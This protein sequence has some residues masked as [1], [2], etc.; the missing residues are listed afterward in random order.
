LTATAIEFERN[1]TPGHISYRISRSP[2]LPKVYAGGGEFL[3]GDA[4]GPGKGEPLYPGHPL[5]LAAIEEA[6]RATSRPFVVEL[7]PGEAGLPESLAPHVGRRGQF[8][9]TKVAYRGLEPVDHFLATALVEGHQ[10]PI[11]L[12]VEALLSLA[13]RDAPAPE[14]PLA[15]DDAEIEDAVQEAVLR[16][17]AETM[18]EDQKRF[19]RKLA[20]LDRYLEDQVLVLKRK[21]ASEERRLAERQRRRATA[22]SALAHNDR[23]VQLS[24]REIRRLKERI[25]R[26][27]QGED[28]DYKKWRDNLYERRFKRPTVER[29]LQV[30]FRVVA[31]AR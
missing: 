10:E 12:T 3:I 15:L 31:G 4:R 5:V 9:V 19:E 7:A 13:M 28:D 2:I 26:L 23:E 18:K 20:Q 16:D 24:E 27:Q 22:P 25:E 29:I 14:P 17:Q 11:E 8:V 1:E 6:R 21:C 30:N